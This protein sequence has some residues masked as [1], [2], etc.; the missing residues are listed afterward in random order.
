MRT[1]RVLL[2]FGL[3]RV[4]TRHCVAIVAVLVRRAAVVRPAVRTTATYAI[5]RAVG[6]TL[7]VTHVVDDQLR[8]RFVSVVIAATTTSAAHTFGI[9]TWATRRR[10]RQSIV[11]AFTFGFLGHLAAAVHVVE[12]MRGRGRRFG[13]SRWRYGR[14][15]SFGCVFGIHARIATGWVACARMVLLLLLV[16][17]DE[18]AGH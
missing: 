2:L 18:R 14:F 1:A 4:L 9:T 17:I 15:E 6:R 12:T 7:V 5:R 3:F 11:F 16:V 8:V 10:R 13:G